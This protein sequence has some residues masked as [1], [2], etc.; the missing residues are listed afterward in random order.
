VDAAASGPASRRTLRDVVLASLIGTTVEWYDFSI[1]SASSALV[2]RAT[3]FPAV[4]PNLGILLTFL[5][6]GVGFARRSSTSPRPSR[7]ITQRK[8]WASSRGCF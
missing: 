6:Y 3:F 2:F 7:C 4:A 5:T 8:I 1:F